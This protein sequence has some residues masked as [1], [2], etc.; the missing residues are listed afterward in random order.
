MAREISL[1]QT[2]NQQIYAYYFKEAG[3]Y[4]IWGT[5]VTVGADTY[6]TL[7]ADSIM[8]HSGEIF[9]SRWEPVTDPPPSQ[10]RNNAPTC[11]QRL[12][13]EEA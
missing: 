5:E 13:K 1:F 4:L 12:E 8:C 9:R 2:R 3:S 10:P 7:E 6:A 11:W